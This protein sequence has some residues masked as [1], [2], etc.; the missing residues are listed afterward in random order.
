MSHPLFLFLPFSG[1]RNVL[2]YAFLYCSGNDPKLIIIVGGG[3]GGGG[4]GSGSGGVTV[5]VLVL[6]TAF[7]TQYK[8]LFTTESFFKMKSLALFFL[9]RTTA[10]TTL[11]IVIF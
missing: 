4:S 8:N 7:Q 11:W 10:T 6:V 9:Y 2:L 5:L 3:G 1:G